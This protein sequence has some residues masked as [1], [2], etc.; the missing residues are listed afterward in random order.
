MNR[1][2]CAALIGLALGLLA[3]GVALGHAYRGAAKYGQTPAVKGKPGPERP[4]IVFVML[5]DVGIDQ[6]ELFGNGGFDP[7]SLPNIDKLAE[8]GMTF[9][10]VWAM[11]ECSPTRA[12]FFTGRYPL[13]TGVTSAIT[14]QM[15]PHAQLSPY[16]T[17]LPRL[18]CPPITDPTRMLGLR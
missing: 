5:D 11:P 18:D 15:L 13:R 17:T 10:N 1:F 14:S 9:S 2:A 3:V 16:E 6:M 8:S 12:A 7:P 4:N